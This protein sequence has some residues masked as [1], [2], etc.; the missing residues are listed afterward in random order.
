MNKSLSECCISVFYNDLCWPPFA[1]IQT[2]YC[3]R[4]VLVFFCNKV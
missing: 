4:E 2:C 1:S 3:A